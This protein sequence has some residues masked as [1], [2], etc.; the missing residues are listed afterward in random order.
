MSTS[1]F[2]DVFLPYVKG[3]ADDLPLS[4]SLYR[5][6]IVLFGNFATVEVGFDDADDADELDTLARAIAKK[7]ENTNT[8]GGQLD[9][10]PTKYCTLSITHVFC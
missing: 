8:T 3:I 7:Q 4:S 9:R 10:L 6:A 5:I 1:N 2:R